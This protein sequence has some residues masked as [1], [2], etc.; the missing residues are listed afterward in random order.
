MEGV[1]KAKRF[2]KINWVNIIDGIN[3]IYGTDTINEIDKVD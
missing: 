1:D 2:N 3:K